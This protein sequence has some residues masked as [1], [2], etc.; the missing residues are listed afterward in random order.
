MPA[1]MDGWIDGFCWVLFVVHVPDQIEGICS[2]LWG[3]DMSHH[4]KHVLHCEVVWCLLD[5]KVDEWE[6]NDGDDVM[7]ECGRYEYRLSEYTWSGAYD[8]ANHTTPSRL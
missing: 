7:E 1:W 6:E 2:V 8:T 3:G 5:D 4:V